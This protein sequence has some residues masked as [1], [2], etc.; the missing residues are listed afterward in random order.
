[1]ENENFVAYAPE[2]VERYYRFTKLGYKVERIDDW[3]YHLEHKRTPN[4]W[5]NNPYMSQNNNEW[6]KIKCMNKDELYSYIKNQKYYL[7]RLS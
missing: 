6:E 1:M 3:I 4:S 7:S 5:I 2:D